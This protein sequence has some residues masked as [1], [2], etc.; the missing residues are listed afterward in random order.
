MTK[1]KVI[2]IGSSGAIGEAFAQYYM[3]HDCDVL[4]LSRGEPPKTIS[5]LQH[6]NFDLENEDSIA[7][8]A[9]HAQSLG[10][11]N[12]IIIATGVLHAED[13]FPEKT[14]KQLDQK[15]FQKIFNINNRH[16]LKL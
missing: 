13:S 14:F 3:Q 10:S 1:E 6:I 2:I 7:N 9:A 12:K 15:F 16:I 11:Y 8:A 4:C 5:S